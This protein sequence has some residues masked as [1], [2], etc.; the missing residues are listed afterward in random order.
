MRSTAFPRQDSDFDAGAYS[1]QRG[2]PWPGAW[3]SAA[4]Q[5]GFRE[6]VRFSVPE[7]VA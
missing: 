4:F 2:H 5:R 7:R 3:A 6:W 1:A